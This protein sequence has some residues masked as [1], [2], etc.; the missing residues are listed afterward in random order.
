[1]AKR[2]DPAGWHVFHAGGA[3]VH[4]GTGVSRGHALSP[5]QLAAAQTIA[6]ENDWI[7]ELY[8]ADAYAVENDSTVAVEH[9]GLMGVPYQQTALADFIAANELIVRAQFVVPEESIPQV[10][11][12]TRAIGLSVASATSPIMPGTAFVS[13]T[14][15]GITKATGIAAICAELGVT[16]DR[17]MMIGDGL[18]DLSAIGAVGHPVA[19]GNAADDVKALA[20]YHVADVDHDGVAEAL[21]MS[22][23]LA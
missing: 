12:A 3:T 8:S 4:T 10:L 21:D 1:M 14:Q 20:R 15:T 13:A 7:L 22:A 9:A 23:E 6:A 16:I 19:M 5:T 11:D 18:N 17:A 2:L